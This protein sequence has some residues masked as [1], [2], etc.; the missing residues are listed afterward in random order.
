MTTYEIPPSLH[1]AIASITKQTMDASATALSEKYGFDL[2]EAKRF[3]ESVPTLQGSEAK[4]TKG[5]AKG[6]A[7]PT[8]VDSGVTSG[9]DEAKDKPKRPQTGYLLFA[10][11]MRAE[12]KEDMTASL[13]EGGKVLPQ[14]IIKEIAARWKAL[15]KREQEVYKQRAKTPEVFEAGEF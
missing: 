8:V 4:K 12:V 2:A 6:K 11:E 3:L 7:K 5:K 13:E 15:E 1:T 14:A 9:S 10:S